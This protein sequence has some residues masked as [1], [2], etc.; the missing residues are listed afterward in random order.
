[1]SSSYNVVPVIENYF[2]SIG[3][4]S[5]WGFPVGLKS[6]E[7]LALEVVDALEAAGFEVVQTGAP[8]R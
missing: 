6:A 1:M 3:V 5:P 8:D 2:R 4:A 7:T